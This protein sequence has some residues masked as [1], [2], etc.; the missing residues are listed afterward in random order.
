M[1]VD[2][3]SHF[4]GKVVLLSGATGT[5]G[6]ELCKRLH[7]LGARLG[8]AVHRESRLRW[9]SETIG[10]KGIL[11]AVVGA[12]DGEAA[13][14]LVKG[15][16]DSLGPIDHFISTAGTFRHGL[17]GKEHASD[18]T[19]LLE[20]NFF[21]VANLVR[22]VVGPMKRR[23][24]GSIVLTGAAAVGQAIPGMALYLAGKAAL[25]QYGSVLQT[26]CRDFGVRVSVLQVGVL[27]TEA[28][29]Q[30][31]PEADTSTWLPVSRLVEALL[32][33]SLGRLSGPGPL[34]LLD[35]P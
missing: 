9:V 21:S 32:D 4:S 3:G 34:Y 24:A 20:A 1:P 31:M 11:S 35:S 7:G 18:A 26:E 28:N 33:A 17:V 29:R 5:V 19:D 30:A 12:R 2:S 25:H 6:S 27:D 8:I 23:R 13:A 16:E 10:D 15:V 14:G 22:A